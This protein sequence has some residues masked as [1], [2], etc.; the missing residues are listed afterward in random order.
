IVGDGAA[1]NRERVVRMQQMIAELAMP[2]ATQAA[3]G[4]PVEPEDPEAAKQ[5]EELYGKAEAL[6]AEAQAAL[7][8]LLAVAKGGK[9]PAALESATTAQAKLEE[10]QQLFYS[11]IE[12]LKKLVRDQGETRDRTGDAIVLDDLARKPMLPPLAQRQD[13]HAQTADA[14]ANA[15]AQQADAAAQQAAQGQGQ[16]QAAP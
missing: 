5:R 1:R 2:P 7:D 13:G 4:Q 12:H 14:I 11:V 8:Q 3:P 16:G 15:L 6:R 9:G 10:M